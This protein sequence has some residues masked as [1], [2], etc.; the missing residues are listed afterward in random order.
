M[1][2]DRQIF[3]RTGGPDLANYVMEDSW[4]NND[5]KWIEDCNA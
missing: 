4:K 3:H 1:I 2:C 5:H